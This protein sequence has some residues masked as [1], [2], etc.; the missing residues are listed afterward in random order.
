LTSVVSKAS[1]GAMELLTVHEALNFSHFLSVSKENGWN[2]DGYDIDGYD[3]YGNYDSSYDV[4]G[5]LG[6][7]YDTCTFMYH[8]KPAYKPSYGRNGYDQNNYDSNGYNPSHTDSNGYNSDGYN[9]AGYDPCGYNQAGTYNSQYDERSKY[10]S[11]YTV[12]GCATTVP[13]PEA[14]VAANTTN[15]STSA[16]PGY[17]PKPIPPKY[18]IPGSASTTSAEGGYSDSQGS[19]YNQGGDQAK[20]V[21]GSATPGAANNWLLTILVPCVVVVA[22]VAVIVGV[23]FAV[24]KKTCDGSC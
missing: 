14:P 7:F 1:S 3:Q 10:G 5:S 11:S 17:V 8:Y 18:Q 24:R 2:A 6:N 9:S 13:A 20:E 22:V 16:P 23:V 15:T 21:S 12:P 19:N 4:S